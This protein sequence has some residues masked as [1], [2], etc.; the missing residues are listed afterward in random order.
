MRFFPR[1]A[2]HRLLAAL[3][4][5]S[6][7]VGV[8]SLPL[9]HADDLKDKQKRVQSQIKKGEHALD[10]SSARLRRALAR[11]E[12]AQ[13]ELDQARDHLART[14]DKLGEARERN[15]ELREK[16][17]L[18]RE[19]LAQ[20]QEAL[21]R[22]RADLADQREAVTDMVTTI[23]EEGDPELRAFSSMLTAQSSSDI[24]WTQEGQSVMLG[25]ETRAYDELRAAEV[26]LQVREDQ[27]E[28]AEQAVAEQQQAAAEQVAVMRELAAEARE[29]RDRVREVVQERRSAKQQAARAKR[30]DLAELAK[31]R[32]QEKRIMELIA[33]EARRNRTPNY[34][35]QS[36]GGFLTWPMQG[37]YVTSPFGYR[38]HPIYGYYS[39]HNG[40][41]MGGG[42]GVPLI[43]AA[44][45][46]VVSQYYSSSYGNR[47]FIYVGKVN[48]KNLTV[49]YN[50]A[51]GYRVGV[52]ATVSRGQVVG[53][54]GTTG[55]STACHLHFTVLV[56]GVAVNPM[57]WL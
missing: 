16:L 19:R 51:S 24:T 13:A 52:G 57:N 15:R 43:A 1:A 29:A 32:K 31:L 50:H 11:L 34:G 39:L 46:R 41:D 55:W 44:G 37:G 30:R 40:T 5:G 27:L 23:Y 6:L 38:T 10:E 8:V 36:A 17:A 12:A 7:A 9:A 22:G 28:A 35:S 20:A 54:S 53:Y 56:N 45:G 25:R 42:C 3:I 21:A 33:A 47:L 4:A 26:L 2:R 48:G 14:R 49:V 18:A